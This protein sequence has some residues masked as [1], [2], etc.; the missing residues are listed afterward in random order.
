M[1]LFLLFPFAGVNT[2]N[3]QSVEQ[4]KTN[5]GFYHGSSSGLAVH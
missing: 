1:F 3:R 5:N 2:S 4:G